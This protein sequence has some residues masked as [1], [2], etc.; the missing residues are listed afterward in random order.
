MMLFA[1]V[2]DVYPAIIIT[3]LQTSRLHSSLRS[4]PSGVS[5]PHAGVINHSGV[6]SFAGDQL[7]PSVYAMQPQSARDGAPP[8]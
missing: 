4:S 2:N 5:S 6:S 8:C 7:E 3:L 1:A